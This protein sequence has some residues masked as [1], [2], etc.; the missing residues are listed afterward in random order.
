M[1]LKFGSFCARR[2]FEGVE[3][4]SVRVLI[5][6]EKEILNIDTSWNVWVVLWIRIRLKRQ[7]VIVLSDDDDDDKVLNRMQSFCMLLPFLVYCLSMAGWFAWRLNSFDQIY[8]LV[9]LINFAIDVVYLRCMQLISFDYWFD[10][11]SN[12]TVA[13][14][15]PLSVDWLDSQT[16]HIVQERFHLRKIIIRLYTNFFKIELLNIAFKF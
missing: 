13:Y 4:H 2:Y 12:C 8:T 14:C 1:R 9:E 15:I 5:K 3:N 11:C 6:L 16:L 10:D 7:F